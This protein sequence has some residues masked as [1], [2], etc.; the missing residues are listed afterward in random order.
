TAKVELPV[1]KRR[2]TRSVGSGSMR[3]IGFVLAVLLGGGSTLASVCLSV[4]TEARATGHA[5]DVARSAG[6][7]H[8][9]A[10]APHPEARATTTHDHDRMHTDGSVQ[11]TCCQQVR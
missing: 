1:P 9:G 11:L 6:G 8:H 2:Y 3:I 5:V 4:C 10:P 7:H